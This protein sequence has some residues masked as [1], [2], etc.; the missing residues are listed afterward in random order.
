MKFWDPARIEENR[1]SETP[2]LSR[3]VVAIDAAL[4]GRDETGIIV[5][6]LGADGNAYIL[7]DATI[8][9]PPDAWGASA[10]A[11]YQRW[12]ADRMLGEANARAE[13]MEMVIRSIDGSVAWKSVRMN[14]ARLK[15]LLP[16]AAADERGG[17]RHVG[18]F[19]SLEAQMCAYDSEDMQASRPLGI[20]RVETRALA[21]TEL[22][23]LPRRPRVRRI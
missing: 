11:A 23:C 9:G 13:M 7:E 15:R 5:A 16:V 12:R 20:E 10:I 14:A 8:H 17:I 22:L 6:G 3:I 2:E 21:V 1:H 4:T 19:L 18:H